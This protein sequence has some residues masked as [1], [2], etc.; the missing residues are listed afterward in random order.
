MNIPPESTT[1]PTEASLFAVAEKITDAAKRCAFLDNACGDDAP[2]RFRLE[3]L[4]SLQSRADHFFSDARATLTFTQSMLPLVPSAA[5]SAFPAGTAVP[6][7]EE[8]PG[9]RIDRYKLLRRIG[10]GGG[11]IVFLAEQEEPVRRHVALKI[12]KVGMETQSVIARFEA[13]RQT[14]AMMDHPNIAR[15]FD[16]GMTV[17]GRPYFVMELVQGVRLTEYCEQ[18]RLDLPARLKLFIQVCR[19]IQHAHQK[20]IVHGDIKPSNI[21]TALHD[22]VGVPRVID[23][24]IATAT[25]AGLVAKTNA[26]PSQHLTR[27]AGTPAYMSPEQAESNG[28]DIDTRSDIYSLG[29]LLHELLTGRTPFVTQPRAEKGLDSLR[30]TLREG[31]PPCASL[32]LASLPADELQQLADRR[33]STPHALFAALRTDLDWVIKRALEKDRALRYE[34]AN[35]L[36]MDIQR[37]LD[38]EPV[39]ARP[40]TRIYRLRK[41]VRR[42][43]GTFAAGC[44]VTAALLAGFGTSLWL[45]MKER[46]AHHRAV[47][48]ERH[49]AALRHQAE[50]REKTTEAALLVRQEK[51]L[52]ADEIVQRNLLPQ[53]SVEG[54][55]VLRSVGTWY[56]LRGQWPLAA[57][58]LGRV[59]E[60]NHLDP[61]E[62]TTL[63]PLRYAPALLELGDVVAYERFRT[64]L[65][66][67]FSAS[68]PRQVIDRIVRVSLLLPADRATI[69]ALRPMAEATI[70]ALAP[71]R[72]DL[73]AGWECLAVALWEYRQGH[74]VNAIAWSRRALEYRDPA[75]PPRSAMAQAILAM[76]CAQM[77]FSASAYAEYENAR[78]IVEAKYLARLDR[79][80][81][82]NGFWFDWAFARI[83]LAEAG[84]MLEVPTR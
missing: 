13:E 31:A 42:N 46:A 11:G 50:A 10:V 68:P 49:E 12:I 17:R 26:D 71:T 19:A 65:I 69:E 7:A 47:A 25:E 70:A 21:I 48:A 36:A 44:A 61:I 54:A 64:Q 58:R 35:G 32:C 33:Q 4:L 84:A 2:L 81:P 45:L 6:S 79:G 3:H 56:A 24:G 16:A 76:A 83:L 60:A 27:L 62:T 72:N 77:G 40:P 18:H 5:V 39:L 41:L 78:D 57:D 28:V 23:F 22:G 59:L 34:T 51:F 8:A 9:A 52:E 14:L 80:T 30:Q 20:G 43:R 37:Y 66:A 67:H 82:L 63:D 55:A 38:H 15:V 53:P 1:P 74:P 29:V 73:N 75:N